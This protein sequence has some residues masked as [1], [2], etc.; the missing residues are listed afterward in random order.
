MAGEEYPY[1]IFP[2]HFLKH[3]KMRF[4]S[5]AKRGRDIGS[6]AEMMWRIPLKQKAI[7]PQG[8]NIYKRFTLE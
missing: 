7:K 6:T 2:R 1:G 8:Y 4:R 3:S 5:G